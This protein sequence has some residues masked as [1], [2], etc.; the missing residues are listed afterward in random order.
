M[1]IQ[2]SFESFVLTIAALCCR[3]CSSQDISC[4]SSSA[5]D[6]CDVSVRVAPPGD[7]YVVGGARRGPP[8]MKK[9]SVPSEYLHMSD[10]NDGSFGSVSPPDRYINAHMDPPPTFYDAM[11]SCE[12]SA[13]IDIR[14]PQSG[15]NAPPTGKLVR[16]RSYS[17]EDLGMYQ[18]MDVAPLSYEN[19]VFALSDESAEFVDG[20]YSYA[21]T[22]DT[23][24]LSR[25]HQQKGYQKLS[26]KSLS[27]PNL[28]DGFI[29]S[30]DRGGVGVSPGR[31]AYHHRPSPFNFALINPHTGVSG[32]RDERL[33]GLTPSPNSA[34]QSGKSPGFVKGVQFTQ[35]SRSFVKH[36]LNVSDAAQPESSS[37]EKGDI[38]ESVV[39]GR[40]MEG[41]QLP[42]IPDSKV[43]ETSC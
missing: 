25:V 13:A 28:V 17:C 8:L 26:R 22:R 24:V 10:G 32:N 7:H 37:E 21:S 16:H 40:N 11:K 19:E 20:A 34:A 41:R 15:A 27:N 1:R 23:H 39:G 33:T 29:H 31:E 3:S 2:R 9:A 38:L 5:K 43:K 12:A 35:K 6:H 18:K 14:T 30:L 36:R 42:T 4:A